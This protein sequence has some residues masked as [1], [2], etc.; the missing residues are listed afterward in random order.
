MS[1]RAT[2]PD[3][4]GE[5]PARPR[6]S[7]GQPPSGVGPERSG[8]GRLSDIAVALIEEHGYAATSVRD[9]TSACGM[10]PGAFYA[11]FQSKDELLY[12][13]VREGHEILDDMLYVAQR[14]GGGNPSEQLRA[15]IFAFTEFH[16]IYR[17]LA[18]IGN[19][20]YRYL[21]SPRLEEISHYRR[22]IRDTLSAIIV[23][24][25][26]KGEFHTIG[27]GTRE[28]TN[29]MSMQILGMCVR[30]IDWYHDDHSLSKE[31]VAQLQVEL[32]L[33]MVEGGT[34]ES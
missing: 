32:V 1:P 8:S 18:S 20:D 5:P 21:P 24:G 34:R 23:A 14:D 22:R 12:R 33:R 4:I 10:T 7:S 16:T 30:V 11:H 3:P 17:K 19:R 25:I 13:L 29:M 9:I 6:G 15:F 31:R 28:E 27:R 2:G 26:S